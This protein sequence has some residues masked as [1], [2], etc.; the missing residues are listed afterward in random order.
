MKKILKKLLEL[1]FV[2][3]VAGVVG[4]FVATLIISPPTLPSFSKKSEM[5]PIFAA[6][7]LDEDARDRIVFR[8]NQEGVSTFVSSDGIIK[9]KGEDTARKMRAILTREDLIPI[10]LDPWKIFD[11]DRWTVTDF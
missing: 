5:V 11:R 10:D 2:G 1:V 4:G 3:I 6:P 9:V 7:V 8:I